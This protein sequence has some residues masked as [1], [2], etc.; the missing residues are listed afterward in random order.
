MLFAQKLL[1]PLHRRKPR[2][3]L[4]VHLR[5]L[6]EPLLYLIDARGE[7]GRLFGGGTGVRSLD[8]LRVEL[9]LPLQRRLSLGDGLDA[10]VARCFATPQLARRCAD[11]LH[12]PARDLQAMTTCGFSR[13]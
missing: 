10:L 2:E 11:C 7:C 3:R 1:P 12:P 4:R 8:L 13:Q 9:L 5:L 6:R